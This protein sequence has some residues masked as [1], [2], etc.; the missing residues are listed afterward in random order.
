[1]IFGRFARQAEL[2]PREPIA[3]MAASVIGV[4]A[5]GRQVALQLAAIGVRQLQLVDF[6]MV[7]LTNI[8]SQGYWH[9]DLG[10]AKAIATAAAIQKIDPTIEV[11]VICDRYRPRIPLGG[12]VFCCVDA[13]A[14][15]AAIWRS[16]R[17]CSR[18]WADGRMLGEVIRVLAAANCQEREHLAR[19]CFPR[20][21]AAR[22]LYAH[23]T[24]YAANIAAGLMV[25]QFTRYSASCRSIAICRS[26]CW[27][28][29][30]QCSDHRRKSN[31]PT[32]KSWAAREGGSG[33]FSLAL[34]Q[35]NIAQACSCNGV[36]RYSPDWNCLRESPPSADDRGLI[37]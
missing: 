25:H 20:V 10:Q 12:A 14:T 11:E 18:F 37:A 15:R 33:R 16:A 7:E 22:Q 1:M 2:V 35:Q 34:G 21:M 24:V 13:I 4:G 36:V 32:K 29:N 17:D 19:R 5:I 28:V 23:S 6:D 30:G 27:P 26:I 3:S 31:S 9:D 8:T